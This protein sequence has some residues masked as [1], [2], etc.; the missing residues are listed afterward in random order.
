LCPSSFLVISALVGA[1]SPAL[2][3]EELDDDELRGGLSL[4]HLDFLV[5]LTSSRHLGCL[6]RPISFPHLHCP[7][8]LSLLLSRLLHGHGVP[9]AVSLHQ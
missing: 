1:S 2:V 4:L 3:L 8:R 7:D 5:R 9:F 6:P